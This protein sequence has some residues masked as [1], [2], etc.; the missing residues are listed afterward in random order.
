[1]AIKLIK[2]LIPIVVLIMLHKIKINKNT[3]KS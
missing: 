3:V 1:M 2:I